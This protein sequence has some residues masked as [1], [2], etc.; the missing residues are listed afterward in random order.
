MKSNLPSSNVDIKSASLKGKLNQESTYNTHPHHH[1]RHP[2]DAKEMYESEFHAER[3]DDEATAIHA[4]LRELQDTTDLGFRMSNLVLDAYGYVRK[5]AT[6][7][8][9][10]F[11]LLHLVNECVLFA[12]IHSQM[13]YKASCSSC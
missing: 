13:M 5:I 2:N 4:A 11:H 6:S 12:C 7:L 8:S 1:T 9:K 3:I 10:P